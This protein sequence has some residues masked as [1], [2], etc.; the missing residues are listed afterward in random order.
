M[1]TKQITVRLPHELLDYVRRLAKAQRRSI[2][3]ILA[4][5]VRAEMERRP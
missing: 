2:A 1:T 5:M 3:F 4:E